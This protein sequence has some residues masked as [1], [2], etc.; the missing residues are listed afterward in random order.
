[1]RYVSL[2]SG[3]EAASC[4]YETIAGRQELSG[5]EDA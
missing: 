3:I 4:T 2:F 1:M 5:K